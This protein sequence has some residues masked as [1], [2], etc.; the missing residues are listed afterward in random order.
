[1][2]SA[3]DDNLVMFNTFTPRCSV[4]AQLRPISESR[5]NVRSVW[6]RWGQGCSHAESS[7]RDWVDE[8]GKHSAIGCGTSARTP[9]SLYRLAA[10]QLAQSK[11][12]RSSTAIDATDATFGL[13]HSPGTADQ[14]PDCSLRRH[15]KRLLDTASAG[16]GTRRRQQQSIHSKIEPASALDESNVLP[17]LP[18]PPYGNGLRQ[19]IDFT[20]S[21]HLDEGVAHAS[22]VS[23][24]CTTVTP[25]STSSSRAGPLHGHPPT[26]SNDRPSTLLT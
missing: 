3:F 2:T 6:N 15:V 12:S 10:P 24:C 8:G 26:P 20:T 21:R 11:V 5:I 9:G 7:G 16:T 1:M 25:S 17:G 13:V 4:E 18:T 19:V 23:G 14:V 22:S